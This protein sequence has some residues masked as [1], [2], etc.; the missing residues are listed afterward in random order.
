MAR[1]PGARSRPAHDGL[2]TQ[3]RQEADRRNRQGAFASIAVLLLDEPTASLTPQETG[4]FGLLRKLRDEGAPGVRQSQ[5]G[6]GAGDLR[7]SRCCATAATPARAGRW[8]GSVA[9]SRPV[10]DR[11]QRTDRGLASARYSDAPT[12]LELSASSTELGHAGIDLKVRKGEIV[13][14]Y[15]LVGAGRTELAKCVLGFHR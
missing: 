9:G 11:P 12:L 8:P 13:G 15:G 4:L 14:L 7:R 10:D 3:R 6:G 2:R 1:P 5:A